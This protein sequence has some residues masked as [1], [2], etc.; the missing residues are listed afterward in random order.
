MS[1]NIENTYSEL[2]E[3]FFR[4]QN[5]EIMPAPR[6]VIFNENLA[7]VLGLRDE[8]Q[9]PEIF[10]GSKLPPN[11]IPISQAY[12][13]YQ[14]GHFAM[15]GDGRAVLLG[16]Q[17]TP[18]GE[19]FDVQLKG[20]GRT[21]YSRNGDGYA[22]IS[23]MLREYIISEAMFSLNIPTTRSLAVAL[24]GK[25]VVRENILQGAVLTRIASSHIRVGTFNY[26]TA[27]GGDIKILADYSIWRH[28]PEFKNS[29][30]KYVLFLRE[31]A[32]RQAVLI[33]KWQSVGFIHGVMNTDN[34]AISGETI[35]YG[36][37]A[38]M[39]AY[40]QNTVFSSIDTEGRYCYKNQPKIGAWNLSRF[41][42]SLIPLLHDDENKAVQIANDE[43][44]K[45]WQIY[46]EKWQKIMLEKLGITNS[47]TGD[48]DLIKSFLDL[49]AKNKADFTNTFRSISENTL[50]K[51]FSEWEKI[52]RERISRQPQNE[53]IFE[54]M[55]KAS[56]AII[57]RNYRVEQA[58]SAAEQGDFSVMHELVT[59]L[60]NPFENSQKYSMPPPD[61]ACK[62]QTFCGT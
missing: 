60:Q 7:E 25:D 44:E 30:E 13:G 9:S 1:W 58:L 5:P 49:M 8:G 37:C 33:A 45:Y 12:A 24:T 57:P 22:A 41:A 31:V 21:P 15:L 38:F 26:I 16:E 23:P 17:I 3:I 47:E 39:D 61:D 4:K 51:E 27:Y 11:S 19:R 59:A 32:K 18:A 52:W 55:K 29:E 28:F 20:S 10:A 46:F 53:N 34:M 42:E 62:Y 54:I 36:P 14:F 6:L 56:P 43:I 40:D 2:P 50:P 35:D 48:M